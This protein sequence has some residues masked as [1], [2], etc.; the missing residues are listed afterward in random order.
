MGSVDSLVLFASPARFKLKPDEGDL[1][2][3]SEREEG[4]GKKGNVP[5]R[6]NN[7]RASPAAFLAAR[8]GSGWWAGFGFLLALDL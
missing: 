1:P 8:R 4:E 3:E 6:G 7:G 2:R 5:A